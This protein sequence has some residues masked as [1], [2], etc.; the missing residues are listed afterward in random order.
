MYTPNIRVKVKSRLL[1]S[2]NAEGK[3]LV[4]KLKLPKVSLQDQMN[5][6][7]KYPQGIT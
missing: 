3:V 1:G 7:T 2:A 6:F 4:T 5:S